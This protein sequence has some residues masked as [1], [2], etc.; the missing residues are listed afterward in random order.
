M[1]QTEAD[2]TICT[3]LEVPGQCC[4]DSFDHKATPGLCSVCYMA[5]TDPA[6]A[7]T[8]KDW[9]QCKGCSAQLMLLKAPRCGACIKKGQV[10]SK[11]KPMLAVPLCSLERF[12]KDH[13]DL[14]RLCQSELQR[15]TQYASR[16]HIALRLLGNV[17]VEP[18]STLGTLGNFFDV[19]DRIHSNHPKK[20]LQGPPTLKLR[21]PAIYLEGLILVKEFEEQTGYKVPYFVL[22]DNVTSVVKRT[23]CECFSICINDISNHAPAQLTT[24]SFAPLR[25]EIGELPGFSKVSFLFATISVAR[26]GSVDISF[27]DLAATPSVCILQDSP[28]GQGKTKNVYKVIYEGMPWVAKRF[29]DIGAGE[30]QVEIAENSAHLME[31]VTRLGK[32]DIYLKGFVA[33]ANNRGVSNLALTNFKLGVEIVQDGCD[34]SPASGVSLDQYQAACN[35]TAGS[36]SG[37]SAVKILWLFEPRRTTKVEHW[38]GTN[39]YPAWPQKKLGSTLNAFTHYVYQISQE[40]TVL[41]DLQTSAAVNENGDGLNVL[42]DVMMHTTDGASGVGDHGQEGIDHFVDSHECVER[43]AGLKL[44]REGFKKGLELGDGSDDDEDDQ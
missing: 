43:C 34:P 25:S 6:R 1:A 11:F 32:T 15:V 26:D 5:T 16:D 37:V 3:N 7:A 23:R 21:S 31:E 28:L 12:T 41:A 29:K 44:S 9:P 17:G 24:N 19:H 33:E 27:P 8:M 39:E 4:G 20:M 10:L 18:H 42:F 40:T 13:R 35:A 36:E 38:S 22:N 14:V 30:G 2:P